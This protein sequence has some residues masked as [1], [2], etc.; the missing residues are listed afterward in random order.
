[1]KKIQWQQRSWKQESKGKVDTIVSISDK[2]IP[3]RSTDI[4]AWVIPIPIELLNSNAEPQLVFEHVQNQG[5]VHKD[6][7]QGGNPGEEDDAVHLWFRLA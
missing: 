1:M 7:D 5:Q 2:Q 6:F 3:V 4:L